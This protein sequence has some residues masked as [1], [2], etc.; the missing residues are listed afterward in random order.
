MKIIRKGTWAQI[1]DIRDRD[2]VH[3]VIDPP[4]AFKV[5]GAEFSPQARAKVWDGRVHL[6]RKVRGGGLEFPAGLY[7]EVVSLLRGA[8]YG[9]EIEE[10]DER[11][12]APDIGPVE[13]RGPRLRDY[14]GAAI[15]AALDR[16]GGVIR[17]PIRAGK[18]MTAG[19][20]IETLG[21]RSLFVVP[22]DL[23]VRQSA[24]VFRDVLGGVEVSTIG[25]G[26]WDVSGDVVVATIQTLASRLRTREFARFA[27]SFGAVFLDEVHH[28]Q[29]DGDA[30]R[31]AAL[32][33]DARYK[34]GLSATVAVDPKGENDPGA[35]WIRGICGPVVYSV[36]MSDLIERGFLVRPTIRFVAHGA[37]E[38]KGKPTP[39]TLYRDGIVECVP[40]NA[41]I[42]AEAVAYAQAGRGVLVD[43]SRV[44]HVRILADLISRGLPPGQVAAL[45]GNSSADDRDAVLQ[46][47]R[48]RR[49]RVIVGTILGEGIDVPEIEVVVNAEGGRAKVST[50]QRMRNLTPAP[51]KVQAVVVEPIDIHHPTFREW[52]LERLRIYRR[53][54]AF[55]VEIESL[56][57]RASAPRQGGD[58]R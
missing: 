29:N 44:P 52:T 42:A 43:A 45:T 4:F 3:R 35:I 7:P 36:G 2:A 6:V 26:D 20:M 56:E 38:I 40:R 48:A 15:L 57:G 27:R 13:W 41:R 24:D 30:W 9:P 58:D 17:L 51:G 8:G 47:F 53:E 22:S 16:G 10:A 5:A 39:A 11:L 49:I 50:I 34:V 21:T 31:D 28:L 1:T 23:L 33:L 37:E 32:A 54:P 18:T 46:A 25:G 55:R 14:Q 12:P 19:R